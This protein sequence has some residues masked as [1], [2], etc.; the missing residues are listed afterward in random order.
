MSSKESI[1]SKPLTDLFKFKP[2]KEG[3]KYLPIVYSDNYDI[4]FWKLER[5]H[6][7]DTHK[8]NKVHNILEKYFEVIL[9]KIN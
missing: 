1:K 4:S 3:R 9:F 2:K 8:W 7:F 6:P 5:F